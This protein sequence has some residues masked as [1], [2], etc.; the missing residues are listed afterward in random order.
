MTNKIDA[1]KMTLADAIAADERGE[2]V[3]IN[4]S[5]DD[6]HDLLSYARN[7]ADLRS[8]GPQCLAS[9]REQAAAVDKPLMSVL[10]SAIESGREDLR[11]ATDS[12]LREAVA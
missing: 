6:L 9:E 12:A 10:R 11:R 8:G 3:T 5:D 4:L 1:S 2:S 7:A